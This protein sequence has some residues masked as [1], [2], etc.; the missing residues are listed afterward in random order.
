MK[1]LCSIIGILILVTACSY[2]KPKKESVME[3]M[4]HGSMQMAP[5]A[6]AGWSLDDESQAGNISFVVKKDGEPWKEFDIQHEKRMHLIVVRS[7]LTNFQ[8]LHPAMKSDGTWTVPFTPPVEGTYWIYADFVATGEGNHVLRFERTYGEGTKETYQAEELPFQNDFSGFSDGVKRTVD[9]ID[10]W[11]GVVQIT[12]DTPDGF[13]VQV[14]FAM[15]DAKGK[16][17]RLQ[18]YLGANGHSVWIST[19]GEYVHLHPLEY[20]GYKKGDWPVFYLDLNPKATYRSFTQFK[21]NGILHTAIFD[22]PFPQR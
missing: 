9:G 4:D 21:I 7:D 3:H 14:N 10:V 1:K 19:T 8:H 12:A 6:N 17:L 16:D 22:W 20:V 2:E 15:R 5:I 18:Q 13:A 11:M